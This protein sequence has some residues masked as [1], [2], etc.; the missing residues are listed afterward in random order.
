MRLK[1]KVAIVTGG[2]SGIGKAIAARFGAEGAQVV[3][4][5]REREELDQTA[6]EL[7]ASG[8]QAIAVCGEVQS[9]TAVRSLVETTLARW[10]AIDILVNNA[11]ICRTAPFLDMEEAEWDRHMD[12]NLKGTFLTGQAVARVMAEQR[13]GGSIINMSSVNG[14]AAEAD[15]AHY[16]ASKGGI[17]LLTMS[18]ALELAP[19]GIRVN[20]LCPGFIQTRLTQPL[21]D[22]RDA[23]D[24]YLRTIP[25]GRAGQPEEIAD[26]ALF[27]ASEDARYM[28]GHCLVVDGGQFSKLS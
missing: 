2:S 5:G 16:N 20:A 7:Q 6:A 1:D 9:R 18:M 15:Q 4:M 26:T 23:F 28:T 25:M 22:N 21:I 3:I 19:L 14:L 13:T 27:L 17:N 12:V 10:G 11:G 24:S 8:V